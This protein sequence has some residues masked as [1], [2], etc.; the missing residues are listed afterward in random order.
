MQCATIRG[1][2]NSQSKGPAKGRSR[3]LCMKAAV[4]HSEPSDNTATTAPPPPAP[5]LPAT[6]PCGDLTTD[7]GSGSGSGDEGCRGTMAAVAAPRHSLMP[8]VAVRNE[9]TRQRRPGHGGLKTLAT[10]R[11]ELPDL[12]RRPPRAIQESLCGL[13]AALHVGP[14]KQAPAMRSTRGP[15]HH[16]LGPGA[17][18]GCRRRV[19]PGAG[20]MP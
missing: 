18:T 7:P 8:W 16:Q 19:V 3:C 2:E 10:S 15:Q 9:K 11:L 17:R 12:C 1:D 13:A 6:A 4:K 14:S 5:N 20:R